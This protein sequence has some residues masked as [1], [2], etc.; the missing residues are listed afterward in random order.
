MSQSETQKLVDKI[1]VLSIET[2][3]LLKELQETCEHSEVV[4]WVDEY[5]TEFDESDEHLLCLTCGRSATVY[6][7]H[8]SNAGENPEKRFST[9]KTTFQE[10]NEETFRQLKHEVFEKL[11]IV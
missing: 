8:P 6:L 1:A 7:G 4:S 2:K 10:V 11:S 5:D 3:K 9:K